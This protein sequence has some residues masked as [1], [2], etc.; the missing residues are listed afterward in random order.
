MTTQ[1]TVVEMWT[2]DTQN[3]AGFFFFSSPQSEDDLLW[4]ETQLGGCEA[5]ELAHAAHS[6]V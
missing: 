6:V 3:A 1:R 2:V 5:L 4:I